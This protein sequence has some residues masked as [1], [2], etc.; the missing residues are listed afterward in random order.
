MPLPKW[1]EW[2]ALCGGLA[3]VGVTFLGVAY[4][5]ELEHYHLLLIGTGLVF[6]AMAALLPVIGLTAAAVGRFRTNRS[7]RLLFRSIVPVLMLKTYGP[8]NAGERA[9][10]L[11]PVAGKLVA[12]GLAEYV[13]RRDRWGAAYRARRR[14]WQGWR[15][16]DYRAW[17]AF[18][19]R[20]MDF[21]RAVVNMSFEHRLP[22][23]KER[24]ATALV[25]AGRLSP[26]HRFGKGRANARLKEMEM[27]LA[28][29]DFA[30]LES[31]AREFEAWLQEVDTEYR[32]ARQAAG[33]A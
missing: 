23:V 25:F 15:E 18:T 13:R 7:R 30:H 33:L 9:G 26:E 31:R 6:L 3:A 4:V 29:S 21:L 1:L 17:E 27:D 19:P 28:R 12:D 14:R 24:L 11:A 5:K 32:L 10:F 20:A 22:E 8:N 16:S 2:V